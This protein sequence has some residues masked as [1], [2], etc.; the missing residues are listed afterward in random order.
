MVSEALERRK[1]WLF[2]SWISDKETESLP[3]DNRLSLQ[4]LPNR[5][6]MAC[7][8]PSLLHKRTIKKVYGG[9][10]RNTGE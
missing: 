1:Q 2:S 4:N 6:E 7:V 10:K 3:F 8:L 9:V 5:T